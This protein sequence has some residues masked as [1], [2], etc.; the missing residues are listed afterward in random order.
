MNVSTPVVVRLEKETSQQRYIKANLYNIHQ[1]NESYISA[2]THTCSC[3]SKVPGK[4][5]FPTESPSTGTVKSR[6]FQASSV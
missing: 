6:G 4:V 3:L 5:P 1:I 2:H